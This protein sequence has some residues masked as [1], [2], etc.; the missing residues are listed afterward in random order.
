MAIELN[1]TKQSKKSSGSKSFN[2]DIG[3]LFKKKT[4]SSNDRMF[5]TERLALLLETGNSIHP[6]LQSLLEQTE[7]VQLK[8]II[9]NLIESIV[10]G[11]SF[12][13]ALAQHPEMFSTTYVT[14]IGASEQGGFM[15][16][17]LK[18]LQLIEEKRDKLHSTIVSAFS[19]PVFLA[20]FSTVVVIFILLVVFPKFG[21]LFASIKDQLPITTVIL[22]QMSEW[23][24]QFWYLFLTLPLVAGYFLRE[25]IVSVNGKNILDK[26]KFKLPVFSGIFIQIYLVNFLRVMGL[27]LA[28]GVSVM[29]ALESC[30]EVVDNVIF[31]RFIKKLSRYVGEGKGL[32]VGFEENIFMPT[33]VKQ[34]IRTGEQ[35]GN[36]SLAMGKIADFY[37]RELNRKITMLSKMAEPFMLLVMGVV[38][39]VIVASLIL[40]IFKLGR[41]VG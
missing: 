1:T 21:T 23:M 3:Q 4:V 24:L 22:M 32:I 31:K 19:Y 37:E 10:S 7:N 36:L 18:Q 41:A 12:S 11:R 39:G 27:S 28:N 14:L 25:W 40:P 34:T 6:S 8:A 15:A 30:T 5:F 9:N 33:M 35:T 26:I 16:D 29:E 17:V 20:I 38:V 13:K 2:I